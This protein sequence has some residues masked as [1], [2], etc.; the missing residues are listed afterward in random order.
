MTK[1]FTN[2]DVYKDGKMISL[3]NHQFNR[4]SRGPAGSSLND[5]NFCLNTSKPTQEDVDA[6]M[7][8]TNCPHC[9]LLKTHPDNHFLSQYNLAKKHGYTNSYD[10]TSD[11]TR[12]DFKKKQ[13]QCKQTV[14]TDKKDADDL[15]KAEND[16]KARAG[17]EIADAEKARLAAAAAVT[18]GDTV[19][20][21]GG[22]DAITE[23]EK[24]DAIK[25]NLDSQST[26]TPKTGTGRHVTVA[27]GRFPG[28]AWTKTSVDA[29]TAVNEINK[30]N[31][32]DYFCLVSNGLRTQWYCPKMY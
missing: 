20:G 15:K 4:S 31:E 24:A 16:K 25:T 2:N 12:G 21:K 11:E 9:K 19:V 5:N 30:D 26:P 10:R 13:A 23:K 32:S 1:Q 7:K 28:N 17:R 3:K 8:V 14:N 29:D 18:M 6:L 22:K 27:K